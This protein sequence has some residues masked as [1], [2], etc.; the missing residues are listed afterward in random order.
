VHGSGVAQTPAGQVAPGAQSAATAR[1]SQPAAA[2]H[3]GWLAFAPHASL[4]IAA[5][6]GCVVA[7]V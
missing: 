3:A 4:T 6:T 1:H 7:C 5:G 2:A